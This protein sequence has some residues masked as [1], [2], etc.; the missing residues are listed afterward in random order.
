MDRTYSPCRLPLADA[1]AV[2]VVAPFEI[3]GLDP[4]IS[5]FIFQRMQVTETLMEADSKGQ[6]LPALAEHWAVSEDHTQWAFRLR[7]GVTF[8]DSSPLTTEVAAHS[9]NVA[10]NK[11]GLL[12]NAKIASIT[13]QGQ[14]VVFRLAAP[15]KP[16]PALLA[17]SSTAILA[18]CGL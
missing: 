2:D 15:F 5:G 18:P 12:S 3:G 1:P 11:P 14:D 10:R 6:P 9:L 4:A 13:A 17:H 7:Q 16:L 8:H